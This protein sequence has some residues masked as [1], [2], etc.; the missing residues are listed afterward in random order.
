MAVGRP[1]PIDTAWPDSRLRWRNELLC[2]GDSRRHRPRPVGWTSPVPPRSAE[3]PPR[4]RNGSRRS[5]AWAPRGRH[6]DGKVASPDRHAWRPVGAV[7]PRLAGLLVVTTVAIVVCT[8][9]RDALVV[10]VRAAHPDDLPARPAIHGAHHATMFAPGQS[11]RPGQSRRTM[12]SLPHSPFSGP[13]LTVHAT[14]SVVP[15][16]GPG[17]G[18]S[19]GGPLLASSPGRS[20]RAPPAD[21][22]EARR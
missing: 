14:G 22:G 16:F 5:R 11:L 9:A 8:A 1:S 20:W 15:S 6:R 12:S 3:A 10:G 18:R 7:V 21:R 13:D 4:G 2:L 17:T 19:S